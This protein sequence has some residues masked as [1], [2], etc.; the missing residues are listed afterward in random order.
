[1]FTECACKLSVGNPA[2]YHSRYLWNKTFVHN[3]HR[4][5][6]KNFFTGGA[7]SQLVTSFFSHSAQM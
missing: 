6:F 3:P 1:M 5:S 2:N 7:V 4:T